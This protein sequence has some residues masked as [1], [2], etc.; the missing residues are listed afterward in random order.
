MHYQAAPVTET[1]FIR[2]VGGAVWDVIVDMRPESPTYL[3]HIGVE[4]SAENRRAVY[5]PALFAHGNQALT[6]GAELLYMMSEFYT[7]GCERGVRYNDPAL[8][9]VWPLPVTL[10]SEKDARWPLIKE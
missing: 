5:V 10:L 7:P 6:D 2:C 3:Q 8:K 9:I 1:K 4:L